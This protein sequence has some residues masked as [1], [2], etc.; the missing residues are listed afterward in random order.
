MD[1]DLREQV[2]EVKSHNNKMIAI[3]GHCTLLVLILLKRAQMRRTRSV[4]TRTWMRVKAVLQTHKLFIGLDF[5][6]HIEFTLIEYN[7][8]H[9]GFDFGDRNS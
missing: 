4:F 9:K 6:G 3:V 2:V 7:D 5:N 1:I 8:V